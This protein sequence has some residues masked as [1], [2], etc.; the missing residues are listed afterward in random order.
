MRTFLLAITFLLSATP[1]VWAQK[2]VGEVAR[3]TILAPR[4]GMQKE[5]EGGYKNHLKWHIDHGDTWNWYGW[6]I[7]SG[8]RRGY[9]VD[10]TFGH[11]WADFDKPV[12]PAADVADLEVNVF[13]FARVLTQFTCTALSAQ[14]VGTSAE[15][16][17]ALPQLAW[18]KIKPGQ[19]LTFEL[20]L[21]IFHDEIPKIVPEQKFLWFR[22]ED[23]EQTPQYLLF[24]PH[25][26]YSEMENT[27]NLFD[28]L[29]SR[30]SETSTL[31]QDSVAEV[32]IETMRYRADMTYLPK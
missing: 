28:R 9:F 23:G 16:S 19:Q 31:I 29:R 21:A 6:F 26:S 17:A 8:T 7:A 15:L 11:S 3:F 22:V 27:Q 24:L 4:E 1:L 2:T 10:T 13:P 32:A 5:F 14:S 30:K 20:F 25:K 12:S 18:F